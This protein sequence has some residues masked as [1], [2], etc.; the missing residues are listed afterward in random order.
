MKD[1]S[2]YFTC[3]THASYYSKRK[4]DIAPSKRVRALHGQRCSPQ[5]S[6]QVYLTLRLSIHI[7][8]EN[9]SDDPSGRDENENIFNCTSKHA[10]KVGVIKDKHFRIVNPLDRTA[11]K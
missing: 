2:V 5:T 1:H 9:P 4:T 7:G 3:S 8:A 6:F 11:A 10:I